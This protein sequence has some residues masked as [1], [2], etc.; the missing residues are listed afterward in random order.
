MLIRRLVEL[1][2]AVL[3]TVPAGDER[4]IAAL[5]ELTARPE[6]A[7]GNV[8]SRAVHAATPGDATAL[9]H[10]RSY[11]FAETAPPEAAHA[12]EAEFF[13]A[14][15]EG[16]ESVEIARQSS[17]KHA[18]ARRS[19]AWRSCSRLRTSTRNLIETALGRA[20]FRHSSPAADAAGRRSSSCSSAPSKVSARR[21]AQLPV[22][23]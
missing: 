17:R 4:T 10:L 9:G 7:K 19:I 22:A 2:P 15:G 16:R 21:F 5:A 12:G 6:P 23:R 1:A 8:R 20:G 3:V 13:S 18:G 11:L 14:P